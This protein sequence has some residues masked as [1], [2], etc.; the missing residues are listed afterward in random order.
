MIVAEPEEPISTILQKKKLRWGRT[1]QFHF[2]AFISII[3]SVYL[4]LSQRAIELYL[5]GCVV[6]IDSHDEGNLVA[7]PGHVSSLKHFSTI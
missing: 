3:S 5:C 2:D 4:F 6:F 1:R 7:L